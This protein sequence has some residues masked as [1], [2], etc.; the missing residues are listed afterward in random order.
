MCEL[1]HILRALSALRRIRISPGRTTDD[2]THR[3]I[4]ATRLRECLK[5]RTY[6]NVIPPPYQ[7]SSAPP[8]HDGAV[9]SLLP[10]AS[11]ASD[12]V[13]LS[14][15]PFRSRKPNLTLWRAH[16]RNTDTYMY[17]YTHIQR[18]MHT[19][20]AFQLARSRPSVLAI[21]QEVIVRVAIAPP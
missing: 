15:F 7:T 14:V 9:L 12:L 18:S 6:I 19:R 17:I 21:V 4:T 10:A 11:P 3:E 13:Q 2:P 5:S 8:E 16:A 1:S 20:P